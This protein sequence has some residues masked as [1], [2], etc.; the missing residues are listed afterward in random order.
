MHR[1]TYGN[2]CI[3]AAAENIFSLNRNGKLKMAH[4]LGYGKLAEHFIYRIIK[5]HKR[6]TF[7][8]G[9]Q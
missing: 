5:L 2:A 9:N 1:A 7:G 8:Q 4:F 6:C 3:I